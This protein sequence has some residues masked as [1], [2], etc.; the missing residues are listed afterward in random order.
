MLSDKQFSQMGAILEGLQDNR[1]SLYPNARNFVDDQVKRFDQYGKDMFL[2]SKQEK[3]LQDLYT[4]FVGPL[5]QL[6]EPAK[7]T[8]QDDYDD[9]EGGVRRPKRSRQTPDDEGR[10]PDPDDDIPF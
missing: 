1:A 6:P 2:S 8:T 10:L 4:E 7:D 5:D 9:P 3:W